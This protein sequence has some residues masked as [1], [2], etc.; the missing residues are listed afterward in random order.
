M[1]GRYVRFPR[2]YGSGSLTAER[3]HGSVRVIVN[4]VAAGRAARV[5]LRRVDSALARL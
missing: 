4:C 2:D 3:W 5:W 1:N